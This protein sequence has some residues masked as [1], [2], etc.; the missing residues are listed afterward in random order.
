MGRG[1]QINVERGFTALTEGSPQA[2]LLELMN[3]LDKQLESLLTEQKAE[4]VKIIPNAVV[5]SSVRQAQ[6]VQPTQ[7]NIDAMKPKIQ[8]VSK[9]PLIY[10]QEQRRVAQERRD[11]ETRQLEARLGRLPLFSKLSDGIA[12]NVPVTPRRHADLPVPLQAV[13]TVKL[14]FLSSIH[15]SIVELRFWEWAEKRPSILKR[16]LNE[17]SKIIQR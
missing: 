7:A 5:G 15:C 6:V 14:L 8:D 9:P 13:K 2:T 17:R 16:G 1:Y 11:A 12:Y 10:T 4:T 3:T